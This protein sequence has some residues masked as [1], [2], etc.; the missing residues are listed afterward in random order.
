MQPSH[1]YTRLTALALGIA[2]VITF[3]SA[4]ATGFQIRE[5]SVKNQGRS[6][7][8]SAVSENDASVVSNNPAAMVNLD[9]VTIRGDVTAIDLTAKFTGGG[10]AAAGTPLAR[11]LT[12]GNG[13]DPGDITAVPAMSIVVPLHGAFEKLTLGA[14]LSAPFGLKTEY[15]SDWVGRYN[16]IESEVKTIDLT[17]SAAI[18]LTDRFSIGAGFVYERAEATLTNAVD[19]GSAICRVSAAACIT[20]NPVAAP[21]GPQKND[22]LAKVKGDDTGIG[23]ILG[24]QWKPTDALAIGYSHRSEIDHDLEGNI[25]FTK[26][27]SVA[28]LLAARGINTYNSGPGGAALTTPSTDTLSVSYKFTDQFRMMFDAQKTDWHSLQSV[29][30]KRAD[31]T[32]ITSEQFQWEDTM[33]YALG[34]E[35]DFNDSF[36]LRGGV[37][38]DESP[39]NDTHRTPRLPDNDRTLY[40]LGLTWNANEHLSVD[41]AYTRI[42]IDSPDVNVVSSSGSTLVGKFKG[43]ADLFGISAQYK[44]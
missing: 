30:I 20:P 22:G 1:R 24:F 44:F 17:L 39:T 27:G 35:Y 33:M 7:A 43:H 38:K 13:G 9:T 26:P 34:A 2:G 23:W 16:A 15:D 5:N 6:F 40:S 12:G 37:A 18:K 21:F 29:D 42:Q 31:G 28:A 14:Q 36:T 11:S 3:G 19:F 25:T 10:N 8:G 41:A 4:G 32:L